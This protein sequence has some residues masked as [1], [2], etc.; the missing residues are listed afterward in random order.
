MEKTYRVTSVFGKVLLVTYVILPNSMPI[1]LK[2][3]DFVIVDIFIYF[4]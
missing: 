1:R 2:M 4:Q 3:L